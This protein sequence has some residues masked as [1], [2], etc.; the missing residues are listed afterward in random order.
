VAE[1]VRRLTP[2]QQRFVQEYLID[3]NATQAAIRAGYSERTAASIGAENLIKPE[4]AQAVEA[5]QS[6]LAAKAEITQ[7]QILEEIDRLALS[8]TGDLF[9]MDGD[10]LRMKPM[11]E[12]P[13]AARRA[14]SAIKIRRYPEKLPPITEE[15]FQRLEDIASGKA[16]DFEISRALLP[17]D[18]AFMKSL[19]ADLRAVYWQQYE[20][21]EIKL[22]DKNSALEKA[23]RHRG[24]FGESLTITPGEGVTFTMTIGDKAHAA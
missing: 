5:A 2:K 1:P 7:S 19:V 24:M 17:E 20:I 14:I 11:K 9:D 10:T 21:L 6:K 12:W 15:Q 8:D 4:I 18:Q 3:L 13:L 23:G 16:Y 22:W